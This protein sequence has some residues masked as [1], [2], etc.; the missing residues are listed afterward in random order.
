ME[1]SV[2]LTVKFHINP[3]SSYT[4]FWSRSDL[5]LDYTK[6]RNIATDEH[7]QSTYFISSVTKE[8][9]GTYNIQVINWA[10][11]GKPNAVTSHVILA[12]TGENSKAI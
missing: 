5:V 2:D 4:L 11:R 12:L 9:L 1:D 7:V 3:V 10:I 8:Q 6:I